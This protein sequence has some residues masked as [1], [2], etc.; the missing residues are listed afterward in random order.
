MQA[1]QGCDKPVLIRVETQG[2]HGY[3][4][5]DKRIAELRRRQ[6]AFALANMKPRTRRRL[7][8]GPA[9]EDPWVPRRIERHIIEDCPGG[10]ALKMRQALGA[11]C[12]GRHRVSCRWRELVDGPVWTQP[13]IFRRLVLLD[14]VGFLRRV[15]SCSECWAP[16][17]A[18]IDHHPRTRPPVTTPS[19]AGGRAAGFAR[20]RALG[21]RVAVQHRHGVTTARCFHGVWTS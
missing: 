4:P 18:R 12:R 7:G 19:P 16:Y 15:S 20:T 21:I 1:A 3:R 9:L 11:L 17:V 10:V 2:S 14:L 5:T 13:R 8:A 6:W